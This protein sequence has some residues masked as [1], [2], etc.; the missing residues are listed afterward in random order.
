MSDPP[1]WREY[2]GGALPVDGGIRARSSRGAIGRS[3]WSGRFI[4]VL[5]SLG[6]GGRLG[7]G[8]AYARAGQVVSMEVDAGSV[9]AQVQGSR[10]RPYQVRLGVSTYGKPEWARIEQAMA[11]DAWYAA[12][13]LAGEMPEDIEERVFG[14]VGL[15]LFPT[16]RSDLSMD[17]TCPDDEVPCKHLA[18]VCYLLAESFDD[19]PFGILALRG[20]DR[21][22]LLANIRARRAAGPSDAGTAPSEAGFVA[23]AG[24]PD[25]SARLDH[26]APL[27]ECLDRYWSA[28]GP[29]PGSPGP[30]TPVDAVLDELP[31]AGLTVGGRTL[32]ELL[33]PVYRSLGE[34]E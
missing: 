22:T 3:W 14:P 28:P 8:R 31:P 2:S 13:L 5:E 30:E 29:L 12:E 6:V 33:R 20:R 27:A 32:S 25:S 21:E 16:S 1:W 24:P 26:T 10:S 17:C 11:D 9:K 23:G 34:P 15:G 18:A 19:D 7:R 4:A